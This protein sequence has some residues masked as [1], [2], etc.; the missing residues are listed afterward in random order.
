MIIIGANVL[1]VLCLL[2]A[3][4]LAAPSTR[5]HDV[6]GFSLP[7]NT[8]VPEASH[9]VC[10]AL[11]ASYNALRLHHR[12]GCSDSK[13]ACRCVHAYGLL[14]RPIGHTLRF[15][16]CDG[17][18]GRSTRIVHDT[19]ELRTIHS[20]YWEIIFESFVINGESEC[21]SGGNIEDSVVMH[22]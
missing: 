10:I 4:V 15:T 16:S 18:C 22:A 9:R 14:D 11:K 2:A 7:E 1:F 19:L 20:I 17:G 21:I 8:G 13:S 5:A 6:T 12:L 3:F